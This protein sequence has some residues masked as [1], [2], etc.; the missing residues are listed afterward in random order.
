MDEDVR[1]A[2]AKSIEKSTQTTRR[3]FVKTASQVAVTGPA[4]SLLLAASTK[5]TAAQLPYL[6]PAAPVQGQDC[7][8]NRVLDNVSFGTEDVDAINLASN[9]NPFNATNNLDDVFVPPPS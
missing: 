4:V 3:T 2:I 5:N 8:L 1:V 9:F 7:D 6:C